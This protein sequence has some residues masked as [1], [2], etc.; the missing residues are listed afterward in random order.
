[1]ASFFLAMAPAIE[2]R[3]VVWLA[4]FQRRPRAVLVGEDGNDEAIVSA[5]DFA[6]E[7]FAMR[8]QLAIFK[9]LLLLF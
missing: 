5:I 6:V 1:M 9:S 7:R 4:S 3:L 2:D 8:E